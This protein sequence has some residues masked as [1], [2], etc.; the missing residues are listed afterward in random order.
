MVI[1]RHFQFPCYFIRWEEEPL[2]SSRRC[3][4]HVIY[5]RMWRHCAIRRRVSA[6]AS[7]MQLLWGQSG[8]KHILFISLI[9]TNWVCRSRA[10]IM[11]SIHLSFSSRRHKHVYGI[12]WPLP[13]V[14]AMGDPPHRNYYTLRL[15]N[16]IG[17]KMQRNTFEQQWWGKCLLSSSVRLTD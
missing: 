5:E 10:A 17:L 4:W 7:R 13:N 9:I 12:T 8:H 3:F 1:P 2:S 11:L 16:S 14:G 15:I 6:G